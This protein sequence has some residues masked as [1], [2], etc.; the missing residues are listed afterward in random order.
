M[1]LTTSNN[2]YKIQ[3]GYEENNPLFIQYHTHSE[4]DRFKF[5]EENFKIF[6]NNGG[7][8][9]H[10]HLPMRNLIV[11]WSGKEGREN[12]PVELLEAI[13]DVQCCVESQRALASS[14]PT[15]SWFASEQAADEELLKWLTKLATK[16]FM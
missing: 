15:I 13:E 12:I 1:S 10:A 4:A 8:L 11:K 5:L 14:F 3:V 2:L 7:C 16:Y 9:H 6:K